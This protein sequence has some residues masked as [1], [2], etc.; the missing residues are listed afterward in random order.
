V[1]W[2]DAPSLS[3]EENSRW[4]FPPTHFIGAAIVHLQ[5][6]HA[7]AAI[8]CPETPWASLLPSL[9]HGTGFQWARDVIRIIPLAPLAASPGIS[10][11]DRGLFC[12]E[13]RHQ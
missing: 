10:A 6:C 11:R 9:W 4:V 12:G 13:T 1:E 3:W 8:I 5:A 2:L 7:S